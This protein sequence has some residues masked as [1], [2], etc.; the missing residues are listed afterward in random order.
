MP[1]PL[2][3][4]W[5]EEKATNPL[6]MIWGEAEA[7]FQLERPKLQ[8]Q[9]SAG[10]TEQKTAPAGEIPQV[11]KDLGEGALK[12]LDI[13]MT[14][15]K[16]IA[17]PI[18]QVLK[19]GVQLFSPS[20]EF[21]PSQALET[22]KSMPPALGVETLRPFKELLTPEAQERVTAMEEQG[23][24]GFTEQMMNNGY[25]PFL[26][27]ALGGSLDLAPYLVSPNSAF[28]VLK[29]GG[30]ESVAIVNK[31]KEAINLA[32][33]Y[34]TKSDL[35]KLTDFANK[36][37]EEVVTPNITDVAPPQKP[38]TPPSVPPEELPTPGGATSLQ[39]SMDKIKVVLTEVR[40]I[41]P[42]IK[43]AYGKKV[44][45]KT[46]ALAEI[47][48][49]E[50]G[51]K[52]FEESKKVLGGGME[53]RPELAK[54]ITMQDMDNLFNAVQSSPR[55]TIWEKQTTQTGLYDLLK[56]G[57]MPEPQQ[58][59]HLEDVFGS[60]FIKPLLSGRHKISQTITSLMN[61]P[62]TLQTGLLPD[63]SATL[64]QNGIYAVSRPIT[65]IKQIPKGIKAMF[66]EK[67]AKD[68]Y[69]RYYDS[70]NYLIK[71]QAGLEVTD[72]YKLA[73]GILGK[74]E[75]VYGQDLIE[76]I[77]YLGELPKATSR[78]YHVFLNSIRD[79]V[80]EQQIRA[81]AKLK[82]TPISNPEQYRAIAKVINTST[83]RTKLTDSRGIN[84]LLANT[85]YSP[86]AIA[87][88]FQMLN[89]HYYYKL[90]P[91]ARKMALKDFTVFVAGGASIVGLLK[92][93]LESTKQGTVETNPTSSDFGKVRVGNTRW[94]FWG[95]FQPLVRT[96]AQL[97]SGYK[98]SVS[99]K[100]T[101]L[102]AKKFP[103]ESRKDV[104][105]SFFAN[106]LAPVP[107][108]IYDWSRAG[109]QFK[110]EEPFW[111]KLAPMYISDIYDAWKEQGGMSLLTVGL[112]SFMGMQTQTYEGKKSF[113]DWSKANMQQIDQLKPKA[114]PLDE[115]WG[116]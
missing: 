91:Q 90:T 98:K 95:G 39:E 23:G 102:D 71:K 20:G 85:F 109:K 79:T 21:K 68:W 80:M 64:V 19:K 103:F 82:F 29:K 115:I 116:K 44:A 87:S 78:A 30:H 12:D 76:R 1:N 74:E 57:K 99:G 5:G 8:V 17:V 104:I 48:S 41:R 89:P 40:E 54:D 16:P 62:R 92:A 27:Y 67:Y 63:L 73:K 33:A 100:T 15:L 42:Q 105:E 37:K 7:D 50:T 2:D 97:S 65:S 38:P 107:R 3:S 32:R 36:I 77:P 35:V 14:Y 34:G 9:T 26:S 25:S 18:Q 88:R 86:R 56:T 66:S 83:L 75:V 4:I 59:I 51:V 60:D 81:L 84:Y 45:Q 108:W 6:D 58:I 110:G 114:N 111:E 46:Q 49:K 101:K 106:K 47:Y 52:A 24:K 43:E 94:N 70:P 10:L 53:A 13:A 61:I 31:T 72:P 96:I 22:G 11:F 55:L 112:P 28:E 69:N 93:Y 113:I